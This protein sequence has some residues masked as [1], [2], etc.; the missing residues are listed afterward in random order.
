LLLLLIAR[1]YRQGAG[2]GCVGVIFV[3][4]FVEIG[5]TVQQLKWSDTHMYYHGDNISVFPYLFREESRITI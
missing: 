5:K 4:S 2:T 3:P 1:G